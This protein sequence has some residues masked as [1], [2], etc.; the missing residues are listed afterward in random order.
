MKVWIAVT[1]AALGFSGYA[2]TPDTSPAPAPPMSP[3]PSSAP[4]AHPFRGAFLYRDDW[5]AAAGWQRS[6]GNPPWLDAITT[7]PQAMWLNGPQELEHLPEHARAAKARGALLVLVAYYIPNRDCANFKDGAPD[8]D[9]YLYWI[10]HLNQSLGNTKAVIIVEPDALLARCF[11]AERAILLRLAVHELAA[12]GHFVYI[13]AGH[14]NWM[15][16]EETAMRLIGVGIQEAQ[17][18]SLNVSNRQ[19]TKDSDDWGWKLS[20]LVGDREFVI[21]TSRNGIGPPPDD[22][23]RHDEWCNSDH[24]ALG[25]RPTTSP[26]GHAAALLWIKPP[27]ESD[28]RCNGETT[29]GFSPR[30][31]A[32]LIANSSLV[33]FRLRALAQA[34]R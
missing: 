19:S 5:S 24:Q 21:D 2:K 15:S 10:K 18:F 13:D 23:K 31:A 32:R 17:G 22:P 20:K 3:A 6:H 4:L 9:A 8:A 26:N 7:A 11:D 12:A 25:D 28:G 29:Y 14:S 16:Q 1:L 27:G 33:P 34:H 30:Q